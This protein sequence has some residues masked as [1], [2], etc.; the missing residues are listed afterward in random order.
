MKTTNNSATSPF[1][2]HDQIRV[3]TLSIHNIE[4]IF[5]G[6]AI[7]LWFLP[8]VGWWHIFTFLTKSGACFET[9]NV[10]FEGNSSEAHLQLNV[11]YYVVKRGRA[12]ESPT[13][14][15]WT[16]NEFSFKWV[17]MTTKFYHFSVHLEIIPF[18]I[19]HK[20]IQMNPHLITYFWQTIL[21][22]ENARQCSSLTHRGDGGWL[23][24]G[25]CWNF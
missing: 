15:H 6:V 4:Y 2:E 25:V 21:H 18:T 23:A 20:A 16:F 14:W 7:K 5:R 9:L 8:N 24:H 12:K 13:P 3:S 11:Q 19:T 1:D 17:T 22:L 10:W